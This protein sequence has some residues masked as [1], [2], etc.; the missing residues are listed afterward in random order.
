MV[1]WFKKVHTL[2]LLVHSIKI[3]PSLFVVVAIRQHVIVLTQIATKY[4]ESESQE[5]ATE[6]I[7]VDHQT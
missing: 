2:V 4:C 3:L 7:L 1:I 5:I 6:V